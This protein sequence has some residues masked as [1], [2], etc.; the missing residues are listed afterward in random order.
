[1][2]RNTVENSSMFQE[3]G[4]DPETKTLEIMF[5]GGQV[6]R[7]ANFT[8]ADWEALRTAESKGKHFGQFI[9]GKFD[10]VKVE[11]DE[12]PTL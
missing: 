11:E 4:F 12:N 3:V 9:R 10:H 1:M 8:P 2:K 5:K 6:Y 7:Y